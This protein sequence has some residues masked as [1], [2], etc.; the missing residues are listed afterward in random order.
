MIKETGCQSEQLVIKQS[1]GKVVAKYTWLL[2]N[3]CTHPSVWCTRTE[4]VLHILHCPKNDLNLSI[5]NE[6]LT[7]MEW[8]QREM[9]K[10]QTA[11][12]APTMTSSVFMRRFSVE[13]K[14]EAE[15][16]KRRAWLGG[17]Q[18]KRESNGKIGIALQCL[19][20]LGDWVRI[21]LGRIIFLHTWIIIYILL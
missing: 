7:K 20:P 14:K 8:M 2:P 18:E 1:F 9:S 13:S 6:Q 15:G 16:G 21:L 3:T 19:W 5:K 17:K 4:H 12:P 10:N 11:A